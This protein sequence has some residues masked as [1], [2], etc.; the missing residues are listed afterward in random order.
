MIRI[1]VVVCCLLSIGL[2]AQQESTVIIISMDGVS[3]DIE[4][5]ASLTAFKRMEQ[6]GIKADH[7]IP[8]YPSTTYPGHVSLATGVYPNRHGILHN[9]FIDAQKGFFNYDA[10]ATGL[11]L[12]P[13][14]FWQNNI[15]SLRLFFSGLDPKLIGT[16]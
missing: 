10:D 11:K 9:S 7:L 1:L 3:H 13:F 2:G 6:L 8:V 14:G 12:H 16:V 5:N 15:A 4:D